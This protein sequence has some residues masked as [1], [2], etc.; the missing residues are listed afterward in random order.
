MQYIPNFKFKWLQNT[1]NICANVRQDI[2]IL[3]NT[4]VAM[5]VMTKVELFKFTRLD[6]IDLTHSNIYKTFEFFDFKWP[7]SCLS[8]GVFHNCIG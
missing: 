8:I 1:V 4:V 6:F 7:S 2:S 3:D 5:A